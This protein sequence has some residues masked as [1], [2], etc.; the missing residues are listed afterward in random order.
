MLKGILTQCCFPQLSFLSSQICDLIKIDFLSALPTELGFKVLSFLDTASLCRAAQVSHRWRVLADDDVVWHNMCEQ[1]I[2]R[3][4]TAC[5]WGLPLLDRER[6]KNEK[7][8]IDLRAR[9]RGKLP[10]STGDTSTKRG[11]DDAPTKDAKRFRRNDTAPW[12]DVYKTRFR[13]GSNWKYGRCTVKKFVGHENGVMCIQ[14]MDNILVTGSYDATVKIWNMETGQLIRTLR[15]HT[16]G[17]RCIQFDRDILMSGALDGS[18]RVWKWQTAELCRTL[19]AHEGGVITLHFTDKLIATGSTDKTIKIYGMFPHQT[20]PVNFRLRGHKDWVNCVKID[21]PSL[22]LMSAS[23]DFSVRMWDLVSR[24]CMRV[25]EGHAGQVQQVLLMPPEYE[26]AF[27]DN[28]DGKHSGQSTPRPVSMSEK[29]PRPS[30]VP[31]A[32]FWTADSK[33]AQ[34]PRYMISAALDSTMRVWDIYAP[35]TAVPLST[36]QGTVACPT[37]PRV[38]THLY[39]MFGHVEGIWGLAADH[40]RLVSAAEDRMVKVWDP[41]TGRCE[42]TFTGHTAPV[43]S[44]ALSDSRLVSGSEDMEV[45]MLTFSDD[46]QTKDGTDHEATVPAH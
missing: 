42:R 28:E 33:R 16:S 27:C 6:L 4:C 30:N 36:G 35:T 3:K 11:C 31:P 24:Q 45:R 14:M 46:F 18:M 12:K 22:T 19:S 20:T 40:L 17:V 21:E 10:A 23:D 9:A 39:T 38:N 44:V 5:G 1:H 26:P 37:V 13:V 25:F 15:G 7:S 41:R 32:P 34:P 8:L 2:D 43:T 29:T